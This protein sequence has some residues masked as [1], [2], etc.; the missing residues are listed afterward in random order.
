MGNPCQQVLFSAWPFHQSR[1]IFG[2]INFAWFCCAGDHILQC[3]Q[4]CVLSQKRAYL[5]LSIYYIYIYVYHHSDVVM[6]ATASQITSLTTVYSTVYSGADQRK[7]QSSASL[8]FVRG[9]HRW[10]VN[11]PHKWPVT[12][13]MFPFEDVSM[14]VYLLNYDSQIASGIQYFSFLSFWETK[15]K[16]ETKIRIIVKHI[17]WIV[18]G[19]EYKVFYVYVTSDIKQDTHLEINE[20]RHI[21]HNIFRYHPYGKALN[22]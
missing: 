15:G 14:M 1:Q 9:I 20:I 7:Y 4:T 12:R 3:C 18:R 17:V 11:S 21:T 8:A 6:G 22:I 10:L 19:I 16:R 2:G 13:I 5:S